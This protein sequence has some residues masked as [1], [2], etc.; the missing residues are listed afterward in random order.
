MSV[1]SPARG[2][3]NWN[4]KLVQRQEIFACSY[5]PHSTSFDGVECCNLV[6][7]FAHLLVVSLIGILN[8]SNGR[9]S[10]LA[11]IILTLLHSTVSSVVIL[12]VSS[13]TCSWC[14]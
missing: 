5:H 12:Y 6:C 9:K 3:F 14:L 13:L 1:R 8:W 4:I 11:P 7:Q 2:V 10:S